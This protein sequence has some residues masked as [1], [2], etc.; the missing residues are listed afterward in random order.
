MF[1]C[2]SEG[3]PKAEASS[4][5]THIPFAPLGTMGGGTLSGKPNVVQICRAHRGALIRVHGLLGLPATV[6]H[7]LSHKSLLHFRIWDVSLNSLVTFVLGSEIDLPG[8][9]N[10][11]RS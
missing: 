1:L 2:V 11:F 6:S 10:N 7:N 4:P 5:T 3:G 8:P 9:E